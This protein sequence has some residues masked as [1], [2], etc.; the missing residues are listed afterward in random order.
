MIKGAKSFREIFFT[1]NQ[2]WHIILLYVEKFM[3]AWEYSLKVRSRRLGELSKFQLVV[4][5]LVVVVE[6]G[7]SVIDRAVLAV[8][9]LGCF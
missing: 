1:S 3:N 5:V 7:P 9:G 6:P 4:A 8:F 2:T